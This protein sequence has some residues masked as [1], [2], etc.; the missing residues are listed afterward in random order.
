MKQI[1]LKAKDFNKELEQASYNI[2]F[3][4]KDAVEKLEDK[5][6]NLIAIRINQIVAFFYHENKLIP[7][8]KF[9]H[10]WQG[11]KVLKTI[12]VDMGAIKFVAGGADIMRPGI[13]DFDQDII[14]DDI[15]TVIDQNNKTIIAIGISM[16]DSNEISLQKNGKT[17]LNIHYIGDNIWK[18]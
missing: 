8:I 11:E 2:N 17:I 5:E 1:R 3:S 7:T 9:L 4:K 14:K 16:F 13:V 15:V 12:T 6:N 10:K 18:T